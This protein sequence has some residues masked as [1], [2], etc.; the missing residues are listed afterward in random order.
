MSEDGFGARIRVAADRGD[1][2]RAQAPLVV[3]SLLTAGIDTTVHGPA[4]CLYA[5]ARHPE[6]R[7]RLWE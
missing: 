6:Q 1:L 7:Q 5:F 4:A 2:T 3:R